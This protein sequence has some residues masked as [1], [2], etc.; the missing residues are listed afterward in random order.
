MPDGGNLVS[1][2]LLTF[3]GLFV[4]FFVLGLVRPVWGVAL[5]MLSFFAC[6]PV[7]VVGE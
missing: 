7:L 1:I 2:T 3:L 4:L 5:Y 6:P